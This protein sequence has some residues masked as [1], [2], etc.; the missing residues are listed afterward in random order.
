MSLAAGTSLGHYTI[1]TPLGAGGMGE[2]YR[3]RDTKLDREVAIKVLPEAFTS[4]PERLSRFERE[5]KSLAA[6]NHPN[7]ATIHGFEQDRDVH[8]LVMELVEG[9][10]LAERL[11]RGPLLVDEAVPLFIQIAE[12]LEA[13]HEKGIIHRDLKPAN[14]MITEDGRVKILDFG[15]AKALDPV[16][17]PD[18]DLTDSPTLTA[19]ATRRGEIM[20]TVLLLT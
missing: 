18:A 14:L 8:F 20:G 2:V 12:G 6:L 19:A 3:A 1:T 15:L 10:G 7:I 11:R 4:D 17:E 16:P 5:A 9:E 13:A